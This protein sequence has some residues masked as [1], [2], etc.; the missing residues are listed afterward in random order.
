MIYWTASMAY[1][2]IQNMI[3]A[4]IDEAK[5]HAKKAL[6]AKRREEMIAAR[7]AAGNARRPVL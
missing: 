2:L 4:R 7:V 3:F 6:K 1:T 5:Y